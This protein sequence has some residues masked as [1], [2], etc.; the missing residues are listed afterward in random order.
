[1]GL[2]GVARVVGHMETRPEQPCMERMREMRG[3]AL[4][5]A[6]S[7]TNQEG[8]RGSKIFEEEKRGLGKEERKN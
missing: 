5:H 6:M 1:M 8:G 7:T 3:G 2:G 4:A